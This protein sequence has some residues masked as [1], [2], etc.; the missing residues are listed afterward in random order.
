MEKISTIKF[1]AEQSYWTLH[2]NFG[3]FQLQLKIPRR[4]QKH[5]QSETVCKIILVKGGWKIWKNGS[6]RLHQRHHIETWLHQ[7]LT[8]SNTAWKLKR[9]CGYWRLNKF[10]RIFRSIISCS[11]YKKQHK[12]SFSYFLAIF[13]YNTDGWTRC[14]C[15][16]HI[17]TLHCRIGCTNISTR[18]F[19]ILRLQIQND[20]LLW[21]VS[22]FSIWFQY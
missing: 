11:F 3:L 4:K 2:F 17:I 22:P 19:W 18:R 10:F 1:S 12:T 6:C 14:L 20:N 16:S 8:S 9:F 7:T 15:C 13:C 21:K 5:K